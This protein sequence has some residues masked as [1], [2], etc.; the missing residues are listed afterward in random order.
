MNSTAN[1]MTR[2]I[3]S[4]TGLFYRLHRLARTVAK[5]SSSLG[6]FNGTSSGTSLLRDRSV[7]VPQAYGGLSSASGSSSFIS[8]T[9]SSGTLPVPALGGTLALT[10]MGTSRDVYKVGT[11]KNMSRFV[12]ANSHGHDSGLILSCMLV[13]SL[14]LLRRQLRVQD[15]VV[16]VRALLLQHQLSATHDLVL[17]L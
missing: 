14:R 10:S 17:V 11:Q 16:L 15:L 13:T 3:S 7:P 1:V 5:H 9:V 6:A 4:C 12:L 8:S 2:A